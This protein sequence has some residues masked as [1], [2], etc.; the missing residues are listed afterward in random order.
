MEKWIE[1][2]NNGTQP[3]QPIYIE[4]AKGER[5]LL[6]EGYA[7][8]RTVQAEIAVDKPDGAAGESSPFVTRSRRLPGRHKPLPPARKRSAGALTSAMPPPNN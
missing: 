1:A 2:A 6:A 7:F 3:L 4:N 5:K 8:E